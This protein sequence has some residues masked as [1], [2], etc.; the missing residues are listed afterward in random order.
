MLQN[1]LELTAPASDVLLRQGGDAPHPHHH[2]HPHPHP[3]WFQL[4]GHPDAFAPAGPGTI[5]KKCGGGTERAVYEAIS[6]ESAL[7]NVTPR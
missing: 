3:H 6:A 7:Q 2:P 1:A 4:S 5:W